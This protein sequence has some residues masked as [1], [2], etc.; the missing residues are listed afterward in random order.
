MLWG[1]LPHPRSL[2]TPLLTHALTLQ[3]L[4]IKQPVNDFEAPKPGMLLVSVFAD[5]DS[6]TSHSPPAS[7]AVPS[8]ASLFCHSSH[9]LSLRL[10]SL[11]FGLLHLL[12]EPLRFSFFSQ[13]L[14]D[15]CPVADGS[16]LASLACI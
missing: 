13:L 9:P 8:L 4:S 1:L 12:S 16:R 7:L 15:R 11:L 2:C 3:M 14:G 5:L 10:P 6:R